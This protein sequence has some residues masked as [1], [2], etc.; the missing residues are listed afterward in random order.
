MMKKIIHALLMSLVILS[1]CSNGQNTGFV[2]SANE[3]DAK[4]KQTKDA[5]LIDVRTA[6]EF[7]GGHLSNA[8]NY[9]WNGSNFDAQI[10]SLDKQK[11]AFVYCLSGGRSSSAAAHM[12]AEGFKQVYEMNGGMMKWRAAGLPESNNNTDKNPGMSVDDYNQLTRSYKKVL[13]DFYAEWC[14]P[15][16]KMKPYLDEISKEM[17]AEVKVVRID[18]DKNKALLQSLKVDALPVLILYQNGVQDWRHD[19]YI[20]KSEVV[21]KIN[22]KK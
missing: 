6:D 13:I 8:M 19:G 21:A 5:Q 9:D 4:L 1:A 15:C 7:Q 14:A 18:A 10:S 20:E 16:K 17:S 11:P 12:R 2:L 22:L 3:F